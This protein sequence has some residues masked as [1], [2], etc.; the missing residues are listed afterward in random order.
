MKVKNMKIFAKAYQKF[1]M[2]NTVKDLQRNR[3]TLVDYDIVLE[4][5][6]KLSSID[7]CE[8]VFCLSENVA[9]WFERVGFNVKPPCAESENLYYKVNYSISVL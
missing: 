8:E 6:K 7:E 9:K 4:I 1:Y 3:I 5:L 2:I